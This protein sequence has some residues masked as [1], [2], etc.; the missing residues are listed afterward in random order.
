M[1]C[2]QKRAP[3]FI[4]A[5][6]FIVVSFLLL[7]ACVAGAAASSVS[8]SSSSLVKHGETAAA[9]HVRKLLTI[10]K[11]YLTR[12]RRARLMHACILSLRREH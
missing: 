10:S 6:L 4:G 1:R 9:V 7:Q 2:F 5:P 8:T 12:V 11:Q 3:L